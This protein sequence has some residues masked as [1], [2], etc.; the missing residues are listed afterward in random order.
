MTETPKSDFPI[1]LAE[2]SKMARKPLHEDS[3]PTLRFLT[4][5]AIFLL[6]AG[7]F[8]L[9]WG[10]AYKVYGPGPLPVSA[11]V[12]IPKGSSVKD[13][14]HILAGAGAVKNWW[15]WWAMARFASDPGQLHAGEYAIPAGASLWDVV[16]AL[17]SGQVIVHKFTVKEGDTSL[18]VV[19]ALK[20][21]EKL[22]GEI[23]AVPPEGSLLPET[24]HFQRGDQRQDVITRMQVAME[25]TL[26][27][28]WPNRADGLPYN[29]PQ[30]AVTM[31][32]I[33][34]KE[35]GIDGERGEIAGVFVNRLRKGMKLQ[36]DPTTI[37]ALTGG[38]GSIQDVLGRQLVRSDWLL[39]NPYNTYHVVGLPPGPIANPGRASIVA[40][41]KPN[42]TENLFFVAD[43]RGGHVFTSTLADHN[44]HVNKRIETSKKESNK[45]PSAAPAKSVTKKAN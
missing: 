29:S 8:A 35:T 17:R 21:E 40:A 7:G 34:E 11:Q 28:L 26:K 3:S 18:M 39:A 25:E 12:V 33:I 45:A 6:M 32:S 22:E 23:T 37:Y 30:E 20:K 27:E 1:K 42:Q 15:S 5:F 31:A 44:K 36:S 38:K 10:A 9:G 4:Y 24:Y 14:A 43:G 2:K 16:L 13:A 19:E 41:L